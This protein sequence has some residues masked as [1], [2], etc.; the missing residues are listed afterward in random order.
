MNF[1]DTDSKVSNPLSH[2]DNKKGKKYGNCFEQVFIY[3]IL[4][5]KKAQLQQKN[6]EILFSNFVFELAKLSGPKVSCETKKVL[7]FSLNIHYLSNF[8]PELP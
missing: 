1:C 5:E 6:L 8:R 2:R 3:H 4:Q 7:A